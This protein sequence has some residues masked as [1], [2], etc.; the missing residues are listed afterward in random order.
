MHILSAP[1][2]PALLPANEFLQELRGTKSTFVHI[3]RLIKDHAVFTNAAY[4]SQGPVW[5]QLACALHRLGHNG[6]GASAGSVAR[7]KGVGYGTV[8]DYTKRVITALVDMAPDVVQWPG[9]CERAAMSRYNA[10]KYGLDGCILSSDGTHCLLYQCPSIDGEV[11]FS[12][13][14]E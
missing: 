2:E 6:T 3:L 14:K 11:Y 12:C 9:P 13:K 5:V 8:L 10:D 1:L 7:S 4:T